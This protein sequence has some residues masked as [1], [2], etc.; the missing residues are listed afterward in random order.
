MKKFTRPETDWRLGLL[1]KR[2]SEIII[3]DVRMD[4]MSG[5]SLIQSCQTAGINSSIIVISGYAEFDYVQ[6]A[7]YHGACCY[8][9][10]PITQE[11]L[12]DA[13]NKPLKN[14]TLTKYTRPGTK[15]P[16]PVEPAPPESP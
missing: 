8:L 16:S 15:H 4:G 13:L 9:L 10:K 7:M 12:F 2:A 14:T 6:N 11:T 1:P 3:T 5:L